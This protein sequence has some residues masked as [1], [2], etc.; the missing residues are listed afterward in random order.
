MTI[1]SGFD[2]SEKTTHSCVVDDDD[3]VVRRDV[4]VRDPDSLRS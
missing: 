2:V 1:Y 3:R 4:V